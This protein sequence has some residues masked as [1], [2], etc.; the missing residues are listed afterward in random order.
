MSQL[1]NLLSLNLWYPGPPEVFEAALNFLQSEPFDLL[2]LQ[3]V[4]QAE[5]QAPPQF[6][7][8]ARLQVAFPGY[9]VHFSPVVQDSGKAFAVVDG[10]LLL[11]RFPLENIGQCFLDVGFGSYDH[12]AT[13]D[14]SGFPALAQVASIVV[15]NK[16]VRLVNVHGPVN[17][18]GNENDM[19]REK[20][21][22]I[23][24]S[25]IANYEYVIV[26][27]D[28]NMQANTNCI[29]QLSQN[30]QNVFAGDKL[31]T[32]FNVRRKNLSKFPGYATAVVDYVFVSKQMRII[33]KSQPQVDVSDHL[34]LQVKL[35]I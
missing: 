8:E 20:L 35:E 24:Q 29:S 18:D 2:F 1:I 15:E 27:G 17:L 14:F 11:S 33:S 21:L 6:Q 19:R 28:F 34:P 31:T 7:K 16:K 13:T 22:A 26:A 4:S 23:I 12:D 9:Y 3:E 30:L 10:Q 32:S 25:E 5:P